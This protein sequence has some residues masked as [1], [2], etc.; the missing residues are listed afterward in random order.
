MVEGGVMGLVLKL[1][2][3]LGNSA[4]APLEPALELARVLLCSGTAAV[5]EVGREIRGQDVNMSFAAMLMLEV[6]PTCS[7][8]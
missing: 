3:E 6:G 8:R 5:R 7:L 2:M 4:T 1:Y